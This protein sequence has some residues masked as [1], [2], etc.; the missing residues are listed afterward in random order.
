MAQTITQTATQD[1]STDSKVAGH[2][3]RNRFVYT[4]GA[5]AIAV[6]AAL[7]IY[8]DTM[9]FTVGTDYYSEEFQTYW[10]PL[11]YG[12]IIFLG[13]FTVILSV[14]FWMTREKD[15]SAISKELELSRYWR[16]LGVFTVMGIWAGCIASNAV[17]SDA[18]WH[19]VTIRDTDFTP[20]HII[21]FYFAL[22]FLTAMLIPAFIWTHT[23]IPAYM[24]K[25]S[26]PFLMVVCGILMIMPN[27]GFNEWGHTFFYAEELF[28]APIH[29]GFVFLGWSLFFLIPLAMQL[30]T[31]MARLIAETT[32]TL[33]DDSN[34]QAA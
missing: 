3:K 12:E 18:A 20:T 17:E 6:G 19:Q 26:V 32:T 25:I 11:L 14:Y 1:I 10:M 24:N 30:F 34:Q 13:S 4:V 8:L 7:R 33:D 21:I 29:W 16:L 5:I 9:G 22:P 31:N 28:A 27:Y 2:F 23:R 15:A